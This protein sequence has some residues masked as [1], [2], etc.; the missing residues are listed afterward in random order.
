MKP[1]PSASDE[2]SCLADYIN[3]S[4]A[5]APRSFTPVRISS[6][7]N[8]IEFL[9][10]NSFTFTNEEKLR[11][12]YELAFPESPSPSNS[13]STALTIPSPNPPAS[14]RRNA[15]WAG[16]NEDDVVEASDQFIIVVV[17]SG[18]D[19]AKDVTNWCTSSLPTHGMGDIA[20]TNLTKFMV[21]IAKRHRTMAKMARIGVAMQIFLTLS[22]GY[23]DIITDFLVAKSYYDIGKL[24][25]AYATAGFA[26]LA[27]AVQTIMTFFQ[28]MKKPW[29]ERLWRTTLAIIGLGPLIEGVNLWTGKDDPSVLL[30]GSA[31][32]GAMKALEI[33]FE[34]V[35]ECIIQVDGLLSAKLEDIQTIQIVGVVSSIVAGAF[36][37]TDANF[38]FI[39]SKY[40]EDPGDPYFGWIPQKG[41]L[42]KKYQMLGMFLFN[43][44]YFSQFVFACSLFTRA[45]ASSTPLIILLGGEFFAVCAYKAYQGE[46]FGLSIVPKTDFFSCYLGPFIVWVF[47]YILACAV[48][49]LIM[50]APM[51]LGPEVF[52][53]ILCWRL[54]TNGGIFYVA[55]GKLDDSHYLNLSTGMFGYGLSIGLAAIGLLL[56]FVNC[57]DDFEC[58]RFWRLKS[59]KQ[60]YRGELLGL[61]GIEII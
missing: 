23:F 33:C 5:P 17:N 52:S 21:E 32:Y 55:L 3:G 57:D 37:I 19:I 11:I 18:G 48:P 40:I 28:Y 58:S 12:Q 49:L 56:F 24:D 30:Q 45:F 14:G 46:L 50:A 42:T 38:G 27:I 7:D 61:V 53:G 6:V 1:S 2:D 10:A 20:K 25:T 31:M 8:L 4:T 43:A 34:A 41:G 60:R 15:G 39:Q 13:E 26:F 47:Y 59:G 36:I 9:R 29:T 16:A 51:E 44:C 54:L 35:P 22:L